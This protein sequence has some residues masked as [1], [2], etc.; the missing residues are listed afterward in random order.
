MAATR[1]SA[2]SPAAGGKDACAHRLG[3]LGTELTHLALPGLCLRVAV[4]C[5]IDWLWHVYWSALGDPAVVQINIP[6]E[7]ESGEMG[8]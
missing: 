7:N 1:L 2:S 6:E 8:K 4:E 5:L 3:V